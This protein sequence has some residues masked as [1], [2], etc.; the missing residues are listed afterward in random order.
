ML[1]S[2]SVFTY[3]PKC[4]KILC[5]CSCDVECVKDSIEQEQKKELVVC[6]SNTVIHPRTMMIHF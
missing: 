5:N 3:I 6:K 1:Q 2:S 4:D